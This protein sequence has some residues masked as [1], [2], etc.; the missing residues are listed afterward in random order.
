MEARLIASCKSRAKALGLPFNL[1]LADIVVPSA[2]PVLGVQ[3][4]TDAG[5]RDDATASVDRIIPSLGYVKGNVRVV[6][7]RANRLKS[8]ATPAELRLLAD[9]YAPS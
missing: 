7:W 8:D 1:T 9:F 6:S 2:C 4:R 5:E 3:L